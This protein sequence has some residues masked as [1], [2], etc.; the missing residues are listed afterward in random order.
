MLSGNWVLGSNKAPGRG[1]T[2][3]FG[4]SSSIVLNSLNDFILTKKH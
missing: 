4:G 3:I 1:K 2:E